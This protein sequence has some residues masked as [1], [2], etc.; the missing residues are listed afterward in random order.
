MP[1]LLSRNSENQQVYMWE[2]SEGLEGFRAELGNSVVDKMLAEIKLEKRAIEKLGQLTLLKIAGLDKYE[3]YQDKHRKPHLKDGPGI[4][5]SHTKNRVMLLV[6]EGSCGV[7]L[8][9]ENP[10][11]QVIAKKFMS[12]K[13]LERYPNENER[14][15]IWSI[16]EAV[17][18][19]FGYH[20]DFRGDMFVSD[21]SPEENK[22]FVSYSGLH[23][24]GIFELELLT[25]EE[26]KAALTKHYEK[27]I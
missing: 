15:W 22:A 8:E 10:K 2:F 20:V 26:Y 21:L 18:K 5:F 25:F 9:I 16:K 14:F 23:G 13:E 1:L 17:F 27:S 6:S 12:E 19:F 11:I 7:D 4:S 3:L 24:K